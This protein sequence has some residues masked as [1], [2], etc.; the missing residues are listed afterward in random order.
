MATWES[1][2]ELKRQKLLRKA[3]K[4]ARASSEKHRL[5]IKKAVSAMQAR[6]YAQL[7]GSHSSLEDSAFDEESSSSSS[8]DSSEEEQK[9]PND[10]VLRAAEVDSAVKEVEEAL[11]RIL[12]PRILPNN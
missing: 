9:V 12:A 5:K 8:S 11:A 1:L 2:R 3:H 10:E 7:F 4:Q 6:R